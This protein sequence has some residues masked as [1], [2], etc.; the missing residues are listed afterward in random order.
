ME[1]MAGLVLAR[2]LQQ[3]FGVAARREAD[4]AD[5]IR[6]I[7]RHLDGAGADA[8]GAAEKNDVFH[9]KNFNHQDTKS[10]SKIFFLKLGVLVSWWFMGLKRAADTNT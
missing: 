4:Q 9:S 6:Q 8:A 1:M 5:L 7:F 3:Q 10:Q 2:L